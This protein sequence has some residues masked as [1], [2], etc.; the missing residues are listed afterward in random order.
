MP[1]SRDVKCSA[2]FGSWGMTSLII[3][4]DMGEIYRIFYVLYINKAK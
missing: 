3:E 4:V 2:A 1:F